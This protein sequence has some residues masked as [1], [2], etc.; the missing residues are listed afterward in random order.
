LIL[1]IFIINLNLKK[2]KKNFLIASFFIAT[3]VMA[4]CTNDEAE[5]TSTN[6]QQVSANAPIDGQSGQ[7]PTT[8]PKP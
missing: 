8:P 1:Y 7:I 3:A 4:S 6:D 2:M 5:T